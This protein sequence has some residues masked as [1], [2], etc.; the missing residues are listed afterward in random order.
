MSGYLACSYLKV[1]MVGCNTTKNM[2]W[3]EVPV[4]KLWLQQFISSNMK[5]AKTCNMKARCIITHIYISHTKV[6]TQPIQHTVD[7]KL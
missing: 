4:F 7:E 1:I 2:G 5:S 3:Y 6:T